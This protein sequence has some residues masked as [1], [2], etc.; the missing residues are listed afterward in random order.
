MFKLPR[1]RGSIMQ[2]LARL[3]R[4]KRKEVRRKCIK[5]ARKGG[6]RAAVALKRRRNA[7]V[8]AHRLA[9]R[10]WASVRKLER[11]GWQMIVLTM[12]PGRWYRMAE[13]RQALPAY[14]YKSLRAWIKQRLFDRGLVERA[15]A[16]RQEGVYIAGQANYLWRLSPEGARLRAVWMLEL[17]GDVE[18]SDINGPANGDIGRAVLDPGQGDTEGAGVV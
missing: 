12:E 13:L 14:A 18:G 16:P 7:K 8:R 1:F 17:D 9:R 6:R 4:L 3:E 15:P 2:E 11:P 10:I 5:A